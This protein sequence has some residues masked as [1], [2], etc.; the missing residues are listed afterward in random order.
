MI[1]PDHIK[2]S[3]AKHIIKL[4]EHHARS[5]IMARLGPPNIKDYCDNYMVSV[6]KID[7]IREFVFGTSSLAELGERWGLLPEIKKKKKKLK[8]KVRIKAKRTLL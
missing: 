1:K 8:V 4:L 3:Q 5:E 6:D 2:K 7:E